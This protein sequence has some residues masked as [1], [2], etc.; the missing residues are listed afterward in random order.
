LLEISAGAEGSGRLADSTLLGA[1]GGSG[2]GA[3]SVDLISSC[4][5]KNGASNF[6]LFFS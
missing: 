6:C 2:S 1:E 5:S 4:F 3:G